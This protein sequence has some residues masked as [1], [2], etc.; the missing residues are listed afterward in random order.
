MS[1]GKL[2]ESVTVDE[3]MGH[4]VVTNVP[5]KILLKDTISERIAELID[6]SIETRFGGVRLPTAVKY[7]HEVITNLSNLVTVQ[8]HN[9]DA[10]VI[11]N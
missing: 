10:A 5:L 11:H 9:R 3:I 6:D 7:T 8:E 1:S 4:F 2:S